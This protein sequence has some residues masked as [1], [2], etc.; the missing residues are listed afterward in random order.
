MAKRY[1]VTGGTG[2]IGRALVLRLVRNGSAVRVLDNN[3]RGEREGLAEVASRVEF[4]QSDVRD[5]IAVKAAMRDIDCVCHLAYINGTEFFYTKPELVLEVAVKGLVNVLDACGEQ[6]VREFVLASSSEVC[7]EPPSIPT[8]E[9]VPMSIPD[10]MNPRYSYA[11]G[12]IISEIMAINYGRKRFKR[13]LIV[14][15]YNVYGPAMGWE[16]VIPQFVLRMRALMQANGASDRVRFPIQGTGWQ[17]RS[18]V[19]IDDFIEGLMAV[20]RSGTHLGI[21]NIGTQEE[22]SIKKLAQM[23]GDFFGKRIEIVPGPA[24]AGG[25]LRRCPDLQKISALGYEPKFSL[26][27]GLAVTAKWYDENA[28]LA[29]A[30]TAHKEC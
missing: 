27:Q 13:V 16:H 9:S 23:V 21:Y 22:V 10:P 20:I 29:P 30:I 4:V 25:V 7:Q 17:T 11:A 28:Y 15:P 1:L 12:K 19:F 2:F 6:G 18:F 8:S 26:L 14:R 5:P 24:A 3:S